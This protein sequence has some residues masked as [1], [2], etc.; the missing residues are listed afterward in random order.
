[1]HRG[2]Y[3]SKCPASSVRWRSLRPPNVVLGETRQLCKILVAFTRPRLGRGQQHVEYLRGLQKRRR[4]EQQRTDR[5]SAGLEVA[6]EL[7]AKRTNL[8]RPP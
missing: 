6:L 7:R 2:G 5:H 3:R 1:M 4:V 8:V